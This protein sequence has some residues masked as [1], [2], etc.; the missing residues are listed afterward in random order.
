MPGTLVILATYNERENLPGL[1]DE[2]LRILPEAHLLVV[3]D[4][5]PDG[6]GRWCDERA[7]ADLRVNCIHRPGKQG[8]GTATLAGMQ[9]GLGRGYELLVTMDAD[10]SH[11]PE[12]LPELVRA[13]EAADIAIGSR[14]CPGGKIEG[15]PLHRRLMSR[16]VNSLTSA[17]LR[18]PTRDASGAFRTYRAAALNKLDLRQ[19]EATGYSY[20]EEILWRLH[21]SGATVTE[22]PITFRDR[23]AGHSK[24]CFREAIGKLATLYRLFRS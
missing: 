18:L 6:T 11:P 23:R 14:Y 15:W 20:L 21:V 12:N 9:W 3:D 7:A 13:T 5:S 17:A 24:A 4:N 2:I 8:L 16:V 22:I 10:W 1:V 19:V